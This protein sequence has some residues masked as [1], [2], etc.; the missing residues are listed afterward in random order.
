LNLSDKASQ[1][2]GRIISFSEERTYLSSL[3]YNVDNIDPNQQPLQALWDKQ[4]SQCVHYNC[5]H[6]NVR[7]LLYLTASDDTSPSDEEQWEERHLAQL[8]VCD[9]EKNLESGP[10]KAA[11]EEYLKIALPETDQ[12]IGI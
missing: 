6:P 3:H 5:I 1:D 8:T 11:L 2:G 12:Y 4:F 9:H 10:G 7:G